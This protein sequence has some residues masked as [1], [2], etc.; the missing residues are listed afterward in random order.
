MVYGN[1][2]SLLPFFSPFVLGLRSRTALFSLRPDLARP[3]ACQTMIIDPSGESE[4]G[5]IQSVPERR[6]N[7]GVKAVISI[8]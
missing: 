3:T 6:F 8:Q 5:G 1:Y 2:Y 4:R 7:Q